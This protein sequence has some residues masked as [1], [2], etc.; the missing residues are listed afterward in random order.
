MHIYNIKYKSMI[1]K[2]TLFDTG[3]FVNIYNNK[4][5]IF[6]LKNKKIIVILI[7]YNI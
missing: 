6:K 2:K 3:L 4:Q 5:Y 7:H 1:V